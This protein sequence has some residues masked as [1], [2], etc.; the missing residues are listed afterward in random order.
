MEDPIKVS[1]RWS[2][3]EMLLAH[4]VHMRYSAQ[5]RKLRRMFLGVGILFVVLGSST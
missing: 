3:E 5:G 2:A 1:Y 4:R